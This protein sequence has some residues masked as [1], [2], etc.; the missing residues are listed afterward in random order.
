[1]VTLIFFFRT[2]KLKTDIIQLVPTFSNILHKFKLPWQLSS[3]ATWCSLHIMHRS[4]DFTQ[5]MLFTK[6][7]SDNSD[8]KL[9]EKDDKFIRELLFK[10]V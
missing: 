4:F 2:P 8:G 5:T 6:L 1:M 7:N 9:S 3:K 10:K